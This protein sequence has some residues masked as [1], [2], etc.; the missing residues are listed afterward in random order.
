MLRELIVKNIVLI[1]YLSINFNRGL[2]VLTGETGTGKSIL[3]DCIGL[4]SGNRVDFNLIRKNTTQASVTAIFDIHENH[5]VLKSLEKY[6]IQKERELIIRRE[7]K[8]DGKSKCLI[9]D[10]LI[11]RN[12]LIEITDYI[13]ELQGQFEDRGLLN[14]KTHLSLLDAFA[15]HNNLIINTENAYDDMINL[16]KLIDETEVNS[17]KEIEDNEWIKQSLDEL[18][19]LE[20]K[21]GEEESL[22]KKRK[23]LMNREK[24]FN[25]ISSSKDIIEKEM[26]IED[27]VNKVI[28]ILDII[29][30]LNLN[31]I[32]EAIKIIDGIKAE[33]EELKIKITS[34]RSEIDESTITLD[35]IEERL[36][37]L[38]AQARKHDCRV[39]NLNEIKENLS[40]KINNIDRNKF[41]LND[42]KTKYKEAVTLFY[43]SS[44][45][46]SNSR[47]NS[48]SLLSKN[49]NMELP[50]LKLENANLEIL[51][52]EV[53]IEQGS[54]TGINKVT[55]LAS[56]NYGTDLLP[57]NKIASGG[58][59][60]RFLLAIKVVLESVIHNR[61]II[62]D[63]IDSGIGGA[64]ANAVGTRLAKLGNTYQTMVVTHSP[65]VTSK[66]HY[67]FL[68]K[69][70]IKN[71]ETIT[72]IV[73]LPKKD[74]IEEIARMLSGNI[75]TDEAREAAFK[76]LDTK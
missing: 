17:K 66:G 28:K 32:S 5:P 23:I 21:L 19:I 64:T 63:E 50:Y 26:G 67:H 75:I 45:L 53:L 20:P 15:N 43:D 65:Q 37:E 61:T 59:L 7:I 24:V 42:L 46:L 2:S 73:E 44:I 9:N 51:I 4:I 14:I 62:F 57:I 10:T 8:I 35:S 58:E 36:H 12:A 52:E 6:N 41:K 27:L 18:I 29:K 54:K 13:I 30:P 71:Q 72:N 56:T 11:T 31:N 49:I 16:K 3:L 70:N 60:S 55:F 47:K 25:A 48:A 39:D 76:L 74:R 68:V 33:I 38:R 69:K 1:E 22:D 34:E 40:Q